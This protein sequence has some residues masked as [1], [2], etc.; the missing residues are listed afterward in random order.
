MA[1]RTSR[2]RTRCTPEA[3]EPALLGL[4]GGR[5]RAGQRGDARADESPDDFPG[6]AFAFNVMRDNGEARGGAN[7]QHH[8]VAESAGP[9][10]QLAVDEPADQPLV[11]PEPAEADD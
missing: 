6:L 8:P 11:A 1:G 5:L 9:Q 10:P 7:R 3:A 2:P 4:A